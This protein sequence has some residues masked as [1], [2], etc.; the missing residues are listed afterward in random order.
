MS[1]IE[2]DLKNFLDGWPESSD[3]NKQAFVR[4]KEHLAGHSDVRLEFEQRPGITS[5]LRATQRTQTERPLFVM[6]DV[7]EDTPRWLSVCFYA[8]LISDPEER[9]D[10][11]PEGLLGE[12]ALCFDLEAY[13]DKALEYVQAR[14][15]EALHSLRSLS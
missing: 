4:L 12:D 15:D 2:Q 7:I 14:M 11:V 6:V 3:Q 9:G 10:E 8:D 1:T 5:S 13:D